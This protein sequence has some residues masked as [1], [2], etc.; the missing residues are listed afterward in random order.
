MMV[1]QYEHIPTE[2]L[3]LI[4]SYLSPSDCAH[5]S[6]TCTSLHHR[7]TARRWQRTFQLHYGH[8]NKIRTKERML[9]LRRF[10]KRLI[11]FD[12]EE[13]LMGHTLDFDGGSRLSASTDLDYDNFLSI[14]EQ[15]LQ[16]LHERKK[17]TQQKQQRRSALFA[18][19]DECYKDGWEFTFV[20]CCHDN[21]MFGPSFC[22]KCKLQQSS[23]TASTSCS[24]SNEQGG[25]TQMANGNNNCNAIKDS[26]NYDDIMSTDALTTQ[27]NVTA[28]VP[29]VKRLY[30]DLWDNIEL[31]LLGYYDAQQDEEGSE[32]TAVA[33]Q[34]NQGHL[35]HPSHHTQYPVPAIMRILRTSVLPELAEYLYFVVGFKPLAVRGL[36][37]SA[38]RR[39]RRRRRDGGV[40]GP[41]LSRRL[42][43]GDLDAESSSLRY[44]RITGRSP[45]EDQHLQGTTSH[46]TTTLEEIN[47]LR[48][49][50]TTMSAWKLACFLRERGVGCL[51][52]AICDRIDLMGDELFE[53]Y[54][55]GRTT[56]GIQLNEGDDDE[57]SSED[58]LRG[59][60][61]LLS[62]GRSPFLRE[63][64]RQIGGGGAWMSPCQCPELVHR[65]C[66]EQKLKL[67]PKFEPWE[68]FKLYIGR[69]G[70]TFFNSKKEN[71]GKS[72][73]DIS[74]PLDEHSN[75]EPIAPRVWIS[76]DNTI[77]LRRS[78]EEEDTVISVDHLGRFRSP[79]ACC[80]TCGW[81]F[82]RTVRLPRSKWEV[83]AAS[84]SDPISLMRA[85]STF[86]HFLLVCAFIAACE[87][88]CSEC[89]THR[90]LMTTSLGVFKWPTTGLNG[91][92]LAYWQLQ[93]CCML[94]IFFSPRFAAIVDRLWLG[95]ISLFYCRLYFYFLVTSAVL[96]VSY[97]PMVTRT[98][99]VNIL[100]SFIPSWVLES[101][102][103]VG[104]AVA[105]ANLF[106]YAIVSTTVICIFWRTNIRI[107]TVADGKDAVAI[108]RRREDFVRNENRGVGDQGGVALQNINVD[109]DVAMNH[110]VPI[111]QR[112]VGVGAGDNNAASHP[113]Y[114]GPWQ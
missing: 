71:N 92:A 97:I 67:I 74:L 75:E 59:T 13:H 29:S 84:L 30:V 96:A 44:V 45:Q 26:S 24:P 103:P 11:K 58:E 39:R 114:H 5:L 104:N 62:S 88:M 99:R 43:G 93:Q 64:Q 28:L 9:K 48:D 56:T 72:N 54:D 90:I 78:Q 40:M 25:S 69:V 20:G 63:F 7:W 102:Q 37:E 70:T 3:G 16:T 32:T 107:F 86:V 80:E 18:K 76:Y 89:D 12:K 47:S 19:Y 98:I 34:R 51:R 57:N 10:R 31:A 101:L 23:T 33:G 94:H 113:I 73:H 8:R 83:L 112:I 36:N 100:E 46:S 65:Q 42:S 35:F 27:F 15:Q 87:G 60:T 105:L 68:R 109:P 22:T 2:I 1:V 95:P 14:K 17:H 50:A 55:C 111:Q 81:R 110:Q 79:A 41:V 38:V 6:A 53:E 49:A 91:F 4:E 77:P 106:Q 108:L 61:R 21:E 82:L 85:L 66:L 52:C